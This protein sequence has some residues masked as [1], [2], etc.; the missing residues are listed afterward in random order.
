ML[1]LILL[2]CLYSRAWNQGSWISLF[3]K[4]CHLSSKRLLQFSNRK[5]ESPRH[6][7]LSGCCTLGGGRWHTINHHI[8]PRY[9]KKKLWM[10]LHHENPHHLCR[11]LR[12]LPLLK[13]LPGPKC[14]YM[15]TQLINN[16][17]TTISK[18]TTQLRCKYLEL[19]TFWF[20]NFLDERWNIFRN[21]KKSS[22]L[23]FSKLL[24]LSWPG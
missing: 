23:F 6:L 11:W 3:L 14:S 12:W 4:I 22:N 16:G 8:K 21:V 19:S 18:R 9:E 10:S 24:R 7:N 2:G 17:S 5:A 13:C 20:Y 15:M 1:S